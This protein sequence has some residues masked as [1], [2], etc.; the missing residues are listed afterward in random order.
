MPVGEAPIPMLERGGTRWPATGIRR[1]AIPSGQARS[2]T[3]NPW[4]ARRSR[5]TRFRR[6]EPDD[7]GGV[8]L[9]GA[10]TTQSLI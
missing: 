8:G 9:D 6:R 3:G 4:E 5:G 7:A 10:T 1:G 2:G